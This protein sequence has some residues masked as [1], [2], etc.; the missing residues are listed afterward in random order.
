M[1]LAIDL[2]PVEEE[3]LVTAARRAGVAPVAF[4]K[5]YVDSLPLTSSVA[6]KSEGIQEQKT[7]RGLGMFAHVPGGS[8]E[9]AR[10]KQTEIDRE[11]GV[12]G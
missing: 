2:T 7:L 1:I 12:S 10:E 11:D 6:S 4:L 3:R 8:E 5:K 9:Y